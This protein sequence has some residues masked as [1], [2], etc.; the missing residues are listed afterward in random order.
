MKR[1]NAILLTVFFAIIIGLGSWRFWLMF[2]DWKLAKEQLTSAE[3]Q[4]YRIAQELTDYQNQ[5]NTL[6]QKITALEG[7]NAE[8]SKEKQDLEQKLVDLEKEKQLIEARL[9]SLKGLKQAIRQ[10]KI[11]MHEQKIKLYLAR[12]AQQE[13]LDAQELA[14]GNRGFLIKGAQSTYKP[15][16]RI[17]VK[18]VN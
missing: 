15:K 11:E 8:L 9:H 16:I 3:I 13:E 2:K 18:P 14:M 4:Y 1:R 7:N 6:N 17:E 10:V 5:I 12:K